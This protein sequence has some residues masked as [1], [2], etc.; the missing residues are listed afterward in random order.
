MTGEDAI[1]YGYEWTKEYG[2]FHLTVDAKIQKE[3]RPVFHEELDFFGMDKYWDYPKDTD[4]PILWAEGIRRY[5]L[6][7]V[8]VAEALGGGFYS[9][10]VIKRLTEERLKLQ[11]V[12]T[13]RL[14]QVNQAIMMSL[15]QRA[16]E[17][18]QEQFLKYHKQGFSFICAFSGGKDSLALLDITAKALAPNDFYV[19]FSNT[20]MELSDTLE[21]VDAAKKHW[22]LLRFE[23]A[24]SHMDPV[25]S[26][27]EFGPPGRRMRWCCVV[28]KSAPTIIKLREILGNYNAKAVVLDGVRSEESARRAK[29]SDVSVGAKNI[30]QINISPL[31]V[32]NTAELYCYILKQS[33]LFNKAYR[34]GLFR[35]GCM[36]CPLSSD[37]WDGIANSYYHDEM[38]PLLQKV[39]EYAKLNR[40]DKEVKKYIEDGGWKA[41]MGGRGLPNGG[42]R[43]SEQIQNNRI[44]FS[45]IYPSQQW[46]SVAPVLGT[47]TEQNDISGVQNIYG[48]NYE[49]H[50]NQSDSVLRVSY[51]PFSKM[52]RFV[53]AHLRGVAYKVAYCKGCRAC[54]VQCPTGAYTIQ[55]E[56]SILIRQSLCLHCANCLTFTD[57]S[58]LL[59]KS[60]STT[61]VGGNGMDMK[62]LNPYQHFGL[63]QSW[64]E[65]FMTEGIHCFE[66][67]VLGN[68]QYDALKVWL[69]EAGLIESNTKDRALALTPLGMKLTEMGP[70]NPLMWAIV[71]ANLAYNSTISRWYC[72]NAEIGA[73]YEK[74]DLV[75]MLGDNGSLSSRE[76]AVTALAETLRYSPIGDGLKQ[77][78]A[79]ELSKNTYSYFRAG[80]DYPHAVALLY[81][82][83]QYGERT[84]RRSFTFSEMVNAHSN[85]SS[86]GISPSDIYAIE[87]NSFR[88]AVQGLAVQ[89]PKYIRVSFVA[90]LDNIILENYTSLDVLDLAEE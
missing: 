53:I 61:N 42:N 10:P 55:P 85:P 59:A 20:G 50:I 13:D 39:E 54:V 6:N 7:G 64:M 22:P 73:T 37:W 26:W 11:A 12:D 36:V 27:N 17:F 8:C 47:I 79:I 74:G 81:T 33:I 3:I 45:I 29:Y 44:S 89:F 65:H 46:L 56:E 52:D 2:I 69:K 63:R 87:I 21:S 30:S 34:L 57:K 88:E 72:L 75:V 70:Y 43:V 16:I 19:V 15:E 62:G 71:W 82:I 32:W 90:N 78:I 4:R 25:E 51:G 48:N 41:R 67:G 9:K 58:C 68:R 76:N 66:M 23:E 77:G 14:Y 83:Y 35:V 80:W 40:P 18:I 24:K 84:G 1:M 60:L 86:T 49:Y 31:K 5:I 28:H 38:Q